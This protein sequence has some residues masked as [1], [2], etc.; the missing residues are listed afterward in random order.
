MAGKG[1]RSGWELIDGVAYNMC[2][3]PSRYHQ[4]ILTELNR[5]IGNFLAGRPCKVYVAPFNVLLPDHSGQEEEK[6]ATVVQPDLPVIC[7]MEK[8]TEKGCTGAP[9]W[10]V[11]IL[12]PYTSKKD[13]NEKLYLYERHGVRE[14]WIVDPGNKYVHV[15]QLNEK[16]KYPEGPA[17]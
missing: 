9:D 15:Y 11:E 14:Y 4:G 16:G 13:F 3:A 6:V 7:D 5:Q 8:L 17:V 1:Y 2:A 10:I 12:S